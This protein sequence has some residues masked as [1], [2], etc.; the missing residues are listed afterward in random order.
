MIYIVKDYEF[1]KLII[2]FYLLSTDKDLY[3]KV[4]IL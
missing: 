4:I 3:K 1:V 2:I